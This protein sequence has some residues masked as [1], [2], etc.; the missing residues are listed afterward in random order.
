MQK[1]L[2]IIDSVLLLV[3]SG[4]QSAKKLPTATTA[5]SGGMV[6]CR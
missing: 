1:E 2:L 3:Q 5:L 6:N 4:L